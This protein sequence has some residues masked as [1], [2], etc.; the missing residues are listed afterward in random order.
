MRVSLVS[1][2][3]ALPYMRHVV[4]RDEWDSVLQ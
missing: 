2:A 4:R 1:S 3:N